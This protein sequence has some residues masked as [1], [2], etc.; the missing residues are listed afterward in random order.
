MTDWDKNSSVDPLRDSI[1]RDIQDNIQAHMGRQRR[2]HSGYHGI[3]WGGAVCLVGIILLL[4]H[5]GYVSADHLW[6]FWPMLLII[7][8]AIN[9]TQCGKRIWG[10]L[11]LAAGILFQLDA[12]GVL[13]FQWAD[14]WPLVIIAAG[15]MMIWR[16]VD[17]RRTRDAYGGQAAVVGMN[18]TA[19]FGGV[20]RRVSTRDFSR[21]SVTA[22]FGGAEIDFHDADIDGAEGLLEVNAIFG[23]A[24]I[25]VPDTWRVE[26]RGQTLFGGYSDTTRQTVSGDPSSAGVRKTLIITGSTIFGGVEVKN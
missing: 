21:G 6:R 4:D 11:L 7:A 23:G 12:L 5:L 16:S 19:I 25:R 8:G 3:I 14:L 17:A 26:F 2:D 18:A 15:G 20:E 9:L 22:I 1:H 10:S 24:E 13:R